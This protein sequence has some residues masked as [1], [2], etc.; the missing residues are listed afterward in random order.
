[1][2][3]PDMRGR[4]PIGAGTGA[5]LT[6]R[7][8]GTAVSSEESH[9]LTAAETA[10]KGH[11]HGNSFSASTN[12]VSTDHYHNIGGTTGNANQG[13]RHGTAVVEY[14]AYV[15]AGPTTTVTGN[16][17]AIT[18]NV[19]YAASTGYEIDVHNHN[20]PANTGY[21]SAVF[22][23]YQHSHTVTMAG[24]V[25]ALADGASGSA[26]NIM[27]PSYVVNYQIKVH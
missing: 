23:D 7:T 27:Q 20:N 18:L 14:Y 19:T 22:A 3:L 13:H 24:S 15:S 5:G 26:H 10:I 8:L 21:Q 9:V 2:I 11:T 4:A 1:M 17:G 12:V 25:T 16:G 6:A